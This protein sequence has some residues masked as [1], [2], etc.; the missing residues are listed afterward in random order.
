MGKLIS[1]KKSNRE[2][3]YWDRMKSRDRMGKYYE[4]GKYLRKNN[5]MINKRWYLMNRSEVQMGL[6]NNYKLLISS[7]VA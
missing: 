3:N 7:D 1:N 2:I 4:W 6:R 5:I